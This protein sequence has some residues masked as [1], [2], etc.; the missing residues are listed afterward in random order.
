MKKR[1]RKKWGV[2]EFYRPW[3]A[4]TAEIKPLADGDQA[5]FVARFIAE[6]EMR[7][8]RCEGNIGDIELTVYIETGRLATR[9]AERRQEFLDAIGGWDEIVKFEAS[10][11]P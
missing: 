10:E 8:L 3:F 4:F 2:G 9:N 5:N 6:A 11:I 1:L 7:D